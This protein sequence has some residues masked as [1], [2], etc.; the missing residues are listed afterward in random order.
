MACSC[1]L[2]NRLDSR[3][4]SFTTRDM[5][6]RLV[7]PA[8]WNAT[9]DPER[10]L[11][12]IK[13]HLVGLQ[14]VGAMQ[15]ARLC[16][17]LI[18]AICSFVRSPPRTAKSSLQSN[19]NDSPGSKCN[20]TKVPRPVVCCSRCRSAFHRRAKDA[21]RADE[22]VKPRATRSACIFFSVCRS[23]RPFL[24]LLVNQPTRFS[25]KGS[26]LLN[27]S[28]V[29]GVANFGSIVSAFKYFL[30]VLRDNQVR[31]SISRTGRP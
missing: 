26:S 12:C 11:M 29:S 5:Q 23:L 22:P 9:E 10:I 16:D 6:Q 28:G 1:R 31:R 8:F 3:C 18:C 21:T 17:S 15:K 30:M 4:E 27:R 7:D 14:W 13:Q 20:G 25:A 19:W 2:F 24:A